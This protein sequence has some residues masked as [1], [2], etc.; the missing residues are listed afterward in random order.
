MSMKIEQWVGPKRWSVAV[1][2]GLLLTTSAG[3]SEV[4]KVRKNDLAPLPASEKAVSTHDAFD[5]KDCSACHKNADPKNPGGVTT[6]GIELC[7][8]CHDTIQKMLTVK[9]PHS[10]TK[11]SC[12]SCHNPHNSRQAKLLVAETGLLCLS[13]HSAIQT[14]SA[15][16]KVKHDALTT[17]AQCLNCHNPHGT[18]EEH[19]LKQSV[20]G[21]CLNCH[22]Q[23]DVNDHTGRPLT[24]LKKLLDENPVHHGPVD[25]CT[26]C[27][28]PHGSENFRLLKSTYP[29]TF[30]ASFDTKAYALCFDCH[31]PKL[32]T[33]PETTTETQFRNGPKNLHYLHVDKNEFGRTCR[34]CHDIHAAKQE[35]LL[36]DSVPFGPNR[37]PLKT[38][39]TKTTSGGSCTKTCHATHDYV[40]H[41]VSTLEKKE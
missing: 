29:A 28:S 19:L 17:G 34:V 4:S 7:L 8:T 5:P 39:Y 20:P 9:H 2:S 26:G 16:V 25:D 27:H 41:S 21:L 40:N 10:A 31:D 30:Y 22:G 3:F 1:L 24:N 38:N 37:W 32:V 14:L 11:D 36:R 18:A 33:S 15:Q 23:D 12:V 6:P 13:C 35:H